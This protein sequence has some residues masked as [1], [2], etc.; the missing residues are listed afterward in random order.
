MSEQ[1][2]LIVF[3]DEVGSTNRDLALDTPQ[4]ILRP[5]K[6]LFFAQLSQ[7]RPPDWTVLKSV[8][9]SLVFCFKGATLSDGIMAICRAW[10]SFNNGNSTTRMRVAIHSPTRGVDE[11]IA[12]GCTLRTQLKTM[13]KH[14]SINVLLKDVWP[15][16]LSLKADIFGMAMNY[17]V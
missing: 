4:D 6:E 11:V 7:T 1:D 15:S 10:R 17:T 12:H 2:I 16:H 13:L 9:D 5:R 3:T 14:K 8:G